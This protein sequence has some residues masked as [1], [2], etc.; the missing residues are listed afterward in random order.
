VSKEHA[1]A[2]E[3]GADQ[4][5]EA[6]QSFRAIRNP[7]LQWAVDI[8]PL[9]ITVFVLVDALVTQQYVTG[10]LMFLTGLAAAAVAAF[11][12]RALLDQVPE[13]L[14]SLW[15]RN[16]IKARNKAGAG[17]RGE[18]FLF[19][20]LFGWLPE[21]WVSWWKRRTTK[22]RPRD[23]ADTGELYRAFIADFE[24]WLNHRLS[25]AVGLVFAIIVYV[26]FPFRIGQGWTF[27]WMG[28]MM[29]HEGPMPL[30]GS[31][32]QVGMAYVMG[33]LV[34]RMIVI[35]GKV[36]QLGQVFDLDIQVQHPDRS[37]GLKPLGDL[38]FS[39]A[40]I[41][42]VPGIFLAGWI[43]AISHFGWAGYALWAPF[44]QRLLLVIFVLA[45]LAFFQPLY[46]VHRAMVRK[47]AEIHKRLDELARRIDELA[48][49]LLQKADTLEA[50]QSQELAKNLAML[51]Q[52]YE[53]SSAIPV[54]PFDKNIVLKFITSQ[55]IPILSLT[56]LG[57]S[58]LKLLEALLKFIQLSG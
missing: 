13:T 9:G 27:N 55:T 29:R 16:V 39:N 5:A 14:G 44:Y 42:T 33:L 28:W 57:P 2:G 19:D 21:P 31:L 1:V 49:Q 48:K 51:R 26:S 4:I 41:I 46:G 11:L 6:L 8:L 52:V 22:A 50:E 54:W 38:C 7:M 34:W 25:W 43:I 3:P 37:G 36:Y 47:R 24:G 15:A 40:L 45:L 56:G 35:A 17:Q 23:G 20:T 53:S 32:T 10:N 58:A 30:L 12:F 18:T